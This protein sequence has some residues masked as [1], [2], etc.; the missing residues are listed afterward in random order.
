[1]LSHSEGLYAYS[2]ITKEFLYIF[3][4]LPEEQCTTTTQNPIHRE[5]W[6]GKWEGRST[7]EVETD[8]TLNVDCIQIWIT[9]AINSVY[10]LWYDNSN[11]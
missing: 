7:T 1:M 11:V 4:V 2:T 6:M 8:C 9:T 5:V 3:P 10:F